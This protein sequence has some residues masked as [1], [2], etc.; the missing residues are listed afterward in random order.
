MEFDPKIIWLIIGIV[1]IF[2]EFI[3]PGLVIAFF[4]CGA[5]ITSFAIWQFPEVS[6]SI[7]LQLLIFIATSILTLVFLRK[8]F[9]NIFHGK[10]V[11][12]GSK[13][14]VNVE[15]GKILPVVEMLKPGEVGG[16]VRYQGTVWNAKCDD[17]VAPGENV[18]LLGCENITLI[19]KKK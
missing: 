15:I 3:M 13:N 19:V 4:G 18:T 9:F 6:Q 11:D 1:L 2:S 8:Y 12:V 7:H 14:V 5:L 17:E 16:K 10:S